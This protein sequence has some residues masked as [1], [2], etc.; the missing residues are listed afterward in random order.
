MREQINQVEQFH[1]ANRQEVSEDPNVDQTWKQKFLRVSLIEEESREYA[2]ALANRDLIGVADA[3]MDL[4]YVT[5]G[6]I[7]V[8][9]LQDKAEELFAEVHRS[10]MTKFSSD[11][12]TRDDGKIVKSDDYEPADL[13]SILSDER[14]R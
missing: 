1:R 6:A 11:A 7:V 10:N 5:F 3:L 13:K 8:H 14:L 4:L 9:G 2:D 12:E